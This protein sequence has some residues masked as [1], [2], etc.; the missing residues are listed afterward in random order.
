MQIGGWYD[1]GYNISAGVAEGVRGGSYLITQAA[2][3]AASNALASAKS[4]LGVHSPSRVFR[5]QVGAMIPAG[6]ALGIRGA[7]PEATDAVELSAKQ[8][9]TATR[10][11]LRPSGERILTTS[12]NCY[13]T[14]I[15]NG[16][17]AN[18]ITVEV[19]VYLD[20]REVAR[21]TAKYTGRQLAY[22]EGL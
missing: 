20:G 17:D 3:A 21:S 11:A 1:L 18:Q 15:H 2:N 10:T 7:T 16:A 4:S 6:I 22:Q 8:L 19:P 14:T 5:D 13:T 12:T 9:L